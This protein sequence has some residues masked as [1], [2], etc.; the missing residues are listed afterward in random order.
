MARKRKRGRP[1]AE[2]WR[3]PSAKSIELAHKGYAEFDRDAEAFGREV[4]QYN[5][6]HCA[7]YENGI[8]V[9]ARWSKALIESLAAQKPL[10]WS[11]RDRKLYDRLQEFFDKYTA[12]HNDR[13]RILEAEDKRE[14]SREK[15]RARDRRYRRRL[16]KVR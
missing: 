5:A 4:A 16:A 14:E 8:A 11:A 1:R 10:P 2:A 7:G 9:A 12:A 3:K 13:V 6:G 15:K